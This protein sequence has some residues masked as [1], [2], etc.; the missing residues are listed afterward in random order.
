[1][2]P[3]H[4]PPRAPLTVSEG[5]GVS[6]KAWLSPKQGPRSV[7]HRCQ[8]TPPTHPHTP[9]SGRRPKRGYA[10]AA[11]AC[12]VR[13]PRGAGAPGSSCR[14]AH[15]AQARGL[16]PRRAEAPAASKCAAGLLGVFEILVSA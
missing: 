9:L 6:V 1:M 4:R 12:S 2:L 3:S 16:F 10:G 13:E 8:R 15:R 14:A 11:S 7:P 5:R